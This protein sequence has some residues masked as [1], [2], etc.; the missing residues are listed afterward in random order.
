M[1]VFFCWK[2]GKPGRWV[3]MS[4]FQIVYF[5]PNHW[6]KS[7]KSKD[8]SC[9]YQTNIVTSG[10]FIGTFLGKSGK[11]WK[12]HPK[13]TWMCFFWVILFKTMVHIIGEYGVCL[14]FLFPRISKNNTSQRFPFFEKASMKREFNRHHQDDIVFLRLGDPELN[15]HLPPLVC[16]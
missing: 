11:T 10:R 8:K 14:F 15:L 5:P 16:R 9:V 6:K 13:C 3:K 1:K 12:H 4:R 2:F 7:G